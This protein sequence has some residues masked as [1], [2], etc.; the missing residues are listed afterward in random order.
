VLRTGGLAAGAL[1]SFSADGS[2]GVVFATPAADAPGGR[3][4]TIGWQASQ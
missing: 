3:A 4:Y 1:V 2:A